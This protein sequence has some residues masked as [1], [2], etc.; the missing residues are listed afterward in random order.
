MRSDWIRL[1]LTRLVER[2]SERLLVQ[3]VNVWSDPSPYDVPEAVRIV[4]DPH[5]GNRI[6]E[7]RYLGEEPL[8]RI[9]REKNLWLWVG[10]K[11]RR[12]Y[13]IEVARE[14]VR[15]AEMARTAA[16]ITR[17][18]RHSFEHSDLKPRDVVVS[19]SRLARQALQSEKKALEELLVG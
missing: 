5:T 4:E 9:Q 3:G 1:N 2:A 19:N 8:E 11:T 17:L 6:I 10:R 18:I 12:L 16:P 13:R 15:N 14:L 7:F